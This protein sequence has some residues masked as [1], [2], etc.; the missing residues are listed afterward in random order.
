MV[1]RVGNVSEEVN[2]LNYPYFSSEQTKIPPLFIFLAHAP[3][4][5]LFLQ[6]ADSKIKHIIEG[7]GEGLVAKIEIVAHVNI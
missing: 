5:L 7:G 3:F 1:I 4:Y 6:T 2:R